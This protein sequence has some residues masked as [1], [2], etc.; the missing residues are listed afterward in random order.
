MEV[1]VLKEGV[2]LIKSGNIDEGGFV[3]VVCKGILDLGEEEIVVDGYFLFK[4]LSSFNYFL[5][6]EGCGEEMWV[7]EFVFNVSF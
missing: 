6:R 4:L 1:C 7:L 2:W 3:G 5:L